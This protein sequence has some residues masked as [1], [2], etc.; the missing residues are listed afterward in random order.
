MLILVDYT[1]ILKILPF[2]WSSS[3]SQCFD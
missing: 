3:S 1:E 2:H